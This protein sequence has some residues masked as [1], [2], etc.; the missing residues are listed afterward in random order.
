MSIKTL[1]Q[2]VVRSFDFIR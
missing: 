1:G 2:Y